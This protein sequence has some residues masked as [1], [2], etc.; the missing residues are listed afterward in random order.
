MITTARLPTELEWYS[1][2]KTTRRKKQRKLPNHGS[3][4]RRKKRVLHLSSGRKCSNQRQHHVFASS[5]CIHQASW[6]LGK[7]TRKHEISHTSAM[8][9]ATLTSRQ[10][11]GARPQAQG[12]VPRRCLFQRPQI[13]PLQRP[14]CRRRG[15]RYR[16]RT[17]PSF[18]SSSPLPAPGTRPC[19]PSDS[20][21]IR[22]SGP[23]SVQ[24]RRRRSW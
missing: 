17:A 9:N 6:E 14:S 13:S 3:T 1:T 5:A 8:R 21:W 22:S 7:G 15:C 12:W 20:S 18:P 4:K 2:L 10:R 23:S 16:S 11:G 24:S 19:T